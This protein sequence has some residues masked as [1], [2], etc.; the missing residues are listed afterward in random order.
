MKELIIKQVEG[1]YVVKE[2]G[3]D[4]SVHATL[5]DAFAKQLELFEER[6]ENGFN[7]S[8]YGKVTIR[9]IKDIPDDVIDK[10]KATVESV[11]GPPNIEEKV[12]HEDVIEFGE[13]KGAVEKIKEAEK[14]EKQNL[15]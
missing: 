5:G 8:S 9:R 2:I 10:Q 11:T 14:D 6:T 15:D 13:K 3:R 1:G 7:E 12:K 4:E